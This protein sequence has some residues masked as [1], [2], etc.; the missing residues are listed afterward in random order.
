MKENDASVKE[1]E[2]AAIA[3][4]CQMNNVP[5]LGLKVVTDI[6]D[7][8]NPAQEEFLENLASAATSLQKALPQVLDYV[9]DET[10]HDEQDE[11]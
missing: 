1:M 3:Y 2:A 11:L 6:V 8:P 10:K 4:V 5:Y 9:C 7:G